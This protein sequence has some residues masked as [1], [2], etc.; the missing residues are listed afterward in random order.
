MTGLRFKMSIALRVALL[1]AAAAAV[2]CEAQEPTTP[3][4][5]RQATEARE[6]ISG[7]WIWSRIDIG[8]GTTKQNFFTFAQQGATFRGQMEY[9]WGGYSGLE[10]GTVDGEHIHFFSHS[11]PP[12]PEYSGT[13]DGEQM[14]LTFTE[15]G[16]STTLELRRL[17]TGETAFA[18]APVPPALKTVPPNGLAK[19]PPMGWNAWNLFHDYI[20]E[21]TVREVADAM[22]ASGMRDA[23]YIYVNVDDEWAGERD[24]KGV[25]RP[26]RNF[27]DMK[28][29]ADSIHARGMKLGLYSSPGPET[30]EGHLGSLGHEEQDAQTYASWGADY[31]KYDWCS[32]SFV[33]RDEDMRAVY[34]K[35]GEA[36]SKTGRP[37]VYSLC[38]YGKQR[39]PEWGPQV[40]GNLWRTTPDISDNWKSMIYIW[41]QQQAISRWN[42]PG[43]WNDPDMLEI[44]NGG[45]TDEEYRTHFS[46]WSM[47]SAPLL[48]GNDPRSM[49]AATIETLTNNEVIA[50][51]QDALGAPPKKL[52]NTGAIEVWMKPL[53]DGDTALLLLNTT[54]ATAS[55]DLCWNE[56]GLG[57]RPSIRDLWAHHDL[58][59]GNSFRSE[60]T[61]HAV[62]MFRLKH[63]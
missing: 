11:D 16:M 37:I 20:D 25:I 61:S 52:D 51:D 7:T 15:R 44:G 6:D 23:G 9:P 12:E 36:L 43:G 29:L 24:Q 59:F 21:K 32:A 42:K 13:I 4:S 27:P 19:R 8:D 10:G 31:L 56:L 1:A 49:S 14:H 45:M 3:K 18:K 33:Y 17:K 63:S 54:N 50:I 5:H 34:Q 60:I 55:I 30:C 58:S 47:L 2:M 41:T 28:A 26:N 53:A 40:G 46:L 35:M 62:Y 38:Q 57:D 22:I 48:A 39:V